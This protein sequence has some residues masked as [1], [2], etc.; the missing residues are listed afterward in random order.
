MC[1]RW[2]SPTSILGVGYPN[3]PLYVPTE[4]G[5]RL[6]RLYSLTSSYIYAI[7]KIVCRDTGSDN[8]LEINVILSEIG[9][10]FFEKITGTPNNVKFYKDNAYLYVLFP[11]YGN[12]TMTYVGGSA[13]STGL[14]GGVIMPS[15]D[16]SGMTEVVVP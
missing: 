11:R 5:A 15:A 10:I 7:T 9:H 12:A 1:K 6:V 13:Y 4:G 8:R 16:V 3:I 2:V 14:I